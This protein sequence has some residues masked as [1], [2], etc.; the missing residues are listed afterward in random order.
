M[1]NTLITGAN[2]GIGLEIAKQLKAKGH[3]I[4]AVCR[5]PSQSLLDLDVEVIADIDVT[6]DNDLQRLLHDIEGREI[7]YLIN[8]AGILARNVL[9]DIDYDSVQQQFVV[10][11]MAPLRV[12]EKLL[13]VLADNAKIGIVTSRMGSIA[14]NDSGS[15]YGYRMSK[16]AANMAAKSLAVD[17]KDQGIAVAALHPGYVKTDM[18][19]HQGYVEA[20]QAAAG[21]I[22]RMEALNLDNTGQFWHAEG[23]VLPW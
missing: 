21:L 16:A 10:N 2:R 23:Q 3:H 15:S 11:A 8:N 12:T 9:G 19:G 20:D 7:D 22:A 5:T 17:L 13:P 6:D 1:H 14:D 18:T 4:L